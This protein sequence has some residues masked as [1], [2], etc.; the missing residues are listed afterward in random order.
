MSWRHV[1]AVGVF[2]LLEV[3]GSAGLRAAGRYDDGASDTEIRIGQTAPYSGPMSTFGTIG[4]TQA[5][6][7]AM[8]NSSGGIHGR[9]IRFI[10]LD[11]G[12]NP[13][14]TV[15]HVRRLVEAD[16][17]LLLF[18]PLGSPTNA[19]IQTY[20]NR[21]KVPQLFVGAGDARFSMPDRYPWTMGFQQSNVVEGGLYAEYI[22][23]QHPGAR[24]GVLYVNDDAGRGLLEG[25]KAVLGKRN[26]SMLVRAES[27][28]L[29]DATVDS[30][31]IALKASGADT[32]VNFAM[33]KAA[34]QAI[35]KSY[36]IGWRPR[37]FLN[38]AAG[39]VSEVLLPAGREKSIGIISI[40]SMKDPTDP[41]W[42][43][44]PAML[45][46]K[47]WMHR[48]YPDGDPTDNS[49]IYAYTLASLLVHVLE[50][51]GDDLTRANV[52]RQAAALK[53]LTLPLLL[54]GIRINTGPAD[55]SPIEQVRLLRFDG[56]RWR[57]FGEVVGR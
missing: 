25:L 53:D 12:H 50:R 30:Q 27:Y 45:Q 2:L 39:S 17:V 23:R 1:L 37:Q 8:I 26:A 3:S 35:R 43:D 57:L 6:Y 47:E 41:Q 56:D 54:P 55:Y 5:A 21:R 48:H 14:K 19:A 29:T 7:F 40:D 51:C 32:F 24:I 11:D 9:K 42:A 31:I 13:A 16:K 52:M 44:D 18:N 15:E 10:S 22:R 49:N 28:E 34:S 4:R 46:W 20:L 33:P 38:Y 36:D